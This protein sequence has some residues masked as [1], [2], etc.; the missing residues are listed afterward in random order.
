MI[1]INELDKAYNEADYPTILSILEDYF[2]KKPSQQFSECK[3]TI[4]NFLNQGLMPPQA[5]KQAL[6]I[7][8]T[9]VKKELSNIYQTLTYE[10][11]T[12]ISL[13]ESFKKIKIQ[14][15]ETKYT[16]YTSSIKTFLVFSEK[17]YKKGLNWFWNNTLLG[18]CQ[19]EYISGGSTLLSGI[20]KILGGLLNQEEFEIRG[21]GDTIDKN[22]IIEFANLLKAKLKTKDLYFVIDNAFNII[23]IR[24]DETEIDFFQDI[25]KPTIE[26]L[27]KEGLT[28]K[29]IL[30]LIQNYE[31]LIPNKYIYTLEVE[32][33]VNGKVPLLIEYKGFKHQDTTKHFL[34]EANLIEWLDKDDESDDGFIANEKTIDG[35]K[36]KN[37]FKNHI[38]SYLNI[39]ECGNIEKL[40]DAIC[41]DFGYTFDGKKHENGK[42]IWEI[43]PKPKPNQTLEDTKEIV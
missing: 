4:E 12:S 29:L 24:K 1:D 13:L 3:S 32:E 40:F 28:N 2:L 38:T 16:S 10:Q 17:N 9:K 8:I 23:K 27:E 11:K 18:D 30:L 19:I 7:F 34:D 43:L 5:S 22:K 25:W 14:Y 37:K 36:F 21:E 39:C 20:E 15:E 35:K 41:N 26:I 6:K 31:P 42:I 33:S